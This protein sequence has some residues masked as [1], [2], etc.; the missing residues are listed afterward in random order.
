MNRISAAYI[1][2][3]FCVRK[4]P[5]CDFV[6]SDH[7]FGLIRP[8]VT[9]LIREIEI[10]ADRVPG[11]PLTTIYIGGGTPSLLALE[12]VDLIMN[13]L[14][15]S[16]AV[17]ETAEITLEVNP[18]T[19]SL[20]S[21]SGYRKAG[22]NRISIG[23]QSFSNDILR[24]LGRIHT[25][26]DALRSVDTCFEAGFR[27]VSC[28][29]ML[30]VPGQTRSDAERSVLLLTEKRVP[31][32]SCYSL[33][34][35]EGTRYHAR[36][37]NNPELLPSE[38]EERKMYHSLRSILIGEGYIHYEISNYSLPGFLSRHNTVYWKALPY[39]GF[40]CGAHSYTNGMRSG[41][42]VSIRRYVDLLSSESPD[43]NLLTD[44]C[45][46]I[47]REEAMKE[48][49]LLGFRLLD[50]VS[51][52]EFSDRFGADMALVFKLQLDDLSR[53]GLIEKT[54]DRICLSEPGLDYANEVFRSFV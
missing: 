16:F 25:A 1:H 43:L 52:R 3:P 27:N 18:G 19:V 11:G 21:L 35:E 54:P 45:I 4:C 53:R 41:N 12:S 28:D 37:M 2:I 38:D 34:L 51:G 6:S 23:V 5:Y 17:D 42:T 49:M 9:S 8:Y 26:E 20:A 50:G 46:L 31:H 36:Y 24:N 30:G 33:G 29:L 10:T 32:I 40:G 44:E 47:D 13:T 15:T 48:F 7:D 22:I 14:R 39:Y